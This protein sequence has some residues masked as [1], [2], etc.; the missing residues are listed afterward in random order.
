MVDEELKWQDRVQL[1][2]CPSRIGTVTGLLVGKSFVLWDSRST[3]YQPL[4]QTVLHSNTEL[5]K[6]SPIEELALCL[7]AKNADE[8][9]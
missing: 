5:R 7:G 9:S 3:W 2:S 6:L 4:N 1:I 8:S